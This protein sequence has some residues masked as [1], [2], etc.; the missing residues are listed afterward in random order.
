[1]EKVSPNLNLIKPI[2][3]NNKGLTEIVNKRT[4]KY[5]EM[6]NH[7]N[8]M[9]LFFNKNINPQFALEAEK[10][11]I[12]PENLL[13]KHSNPVLLYD[14]F[15]LAKHIEY[16]SNNPLK[17]YKPENKT[18]YYD[19]TMRFIKNLPITNTTSIYNFNIGLRYKNLKLLHFSNQ[20]IRS[21]CY[22]Y[23]ILNSRPVY[24][25][26]PNELTIFI[27]NYHLKVRKNIDINTN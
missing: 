22:T 16:I 11:L 4:N 2:I 17:A 18:T 6:K 26:T 15:V 20:V 10:N 9:N 13:K 27:K 21:L 12:T 23:Y 8:N 19:E 14:E 7:L 1:M 3:K 5:N 25:Y 24:L